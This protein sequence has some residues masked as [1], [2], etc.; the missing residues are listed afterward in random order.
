MIGNVLTQVFR[1]SVFE[2]SNNREQ[3]EIHEPIVKVRKVN[4]PS[5]TV[6]LQDEAEL[7]LRENINQPKEACSV[8]NN[9]RVQLDIPPGHSLAAALNEGNEPSI[10]PYRYKIK[11]RMLSEQ[12]LCMGFTVS[13]YK[14]RSW[15]H[16]VSDKVL[17]FDLF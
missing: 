4:I 2:F 15:N 14:T 12:L 13:A 7:T 17:S 5:D 11:I 6:I 3:R 10:L 9:V 16:Y 1:E 8:P